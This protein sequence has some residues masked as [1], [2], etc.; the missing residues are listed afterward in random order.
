[1][2]ELFEPSLLRVDISAL[3]DLKFAVSKR[4]IPE[5]LASPSR[6]AVRTAG[7]HDLLSNR[8]P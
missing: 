2:C 6:Q 4:W 7:S 1:M 5:V 8:I 3:D